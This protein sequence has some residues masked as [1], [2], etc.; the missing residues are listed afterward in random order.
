M[1]KPIIFLIAA[2][3]TLTL[4]PIAAFGESID[5]DPNRCYREN[6][7][8]ENCQY[9]EN[10]PY[11]IDGQGCN[12]NRGEGAY[13]YRDGNADRC[14]DDNTYQRGYRNN[15]GGNCRSFKYNSSTN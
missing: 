8:A 13:C 10:C 7:T 5:Q 1:K 14:M 3:L 9:G 12:A 6:C 2:M 11:A 15:G 4:L